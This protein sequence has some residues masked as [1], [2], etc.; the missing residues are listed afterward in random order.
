VISLAAVEEAE[1]GAD[2]K[3]AAVVPAATRVGALR[4]LPP[5]SRVRAVGA[6]DTP[7]LVVSIKGHFIT[8]IKIASG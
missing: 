5:Q 1:A 3:L 6:A 7:H 8:T 4:H 2:L